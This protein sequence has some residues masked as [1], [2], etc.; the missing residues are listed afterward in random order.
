MKVERVIYSLFGASLLLINTSANATGKVRTAAGV[1][2]YV[3]NFTD[4]DASNTIG[5]KITKTWDVAPIP[6]GQWYVQCTSVDNPQAVGVPVFYTAHFAPDMVEV[7][8]KVYSLDEHWNISAQI[9]ISGKVSKNVD[10]P[11]DN[12]DNEYL[13]APAKCRALGDNYPQTSNLATGKQGALQLTLK[14]KI[15]NGYSFLSSTILYLAGATAKNEVDINDPYARIVIG[16]FAIN[17]PEKCEINAGQSID[18]DFG[19]V[20]TT[21]LDGNHYPVKKA[22]NV[23]CS[24]GEFES[25]LGAVSTEFLGGVSRFSDDY[26]GTSHGGIGIELKDESNNVIKPHGKKKVTMT[27]GKG[28]LPV[29]FAPVAESKG[30]DAGEFNANIVVKLLLE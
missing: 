27:N 8:N 20:A 28:S 1:Y 26:F 6:S 5:T 12:R 23:S 30:I 10:V 29:I 14:K 16:S 21:K 22:L 19:D 3:L 2:D 15:V 17:L 9:F 24:G 11:F 4:Q 18:I 13:N 25:G 7:G